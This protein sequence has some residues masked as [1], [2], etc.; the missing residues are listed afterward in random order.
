MK[1]WIA[2]DH[3]GF[4]GLYREIKPVWDEGLLGGN[5]GGD[6]MGN[7]PKECFPEVTFDNSPQ[8]VELKLVN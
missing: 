8:E 5:W 1:L 2:R 3:R 7:L 4:I 6:Y